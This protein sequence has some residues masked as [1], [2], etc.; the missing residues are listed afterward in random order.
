MGATHYVTPS[1][2]GLAGMRIEALMEILTTSED[3]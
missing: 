3:E 2:D 1:S